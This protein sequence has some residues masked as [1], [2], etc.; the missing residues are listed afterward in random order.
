MIKIMT[1]TSA[2]FTVEEGNKMDVTVLPLCVSI[3]DLHL[4]DLCFDTNDFLERVKKGSVPSS[5]QPPIGDVIEAFE[6]C[7]GDEILSICMADGLSGTYETAM[8]AKDQMKHKERIHIM[9]SKTLCGPHRFLVEKAVRLRDEMRSMKEIIAGLE[10]S[11]GSM[12]SF[13]IPQDFSFLKR[14]GRLKPAAASIGGLLKLKPVMQQV[15][16]GRR[17]DTYTIKRTM[18]KAVS[19]VIASFQKLGVNENFKIYV[20]HAGAL[21]DAEKII[22][23]I[24]AVFTATDIEMLELSPAFITQGGPGC[25]AIQTILK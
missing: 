4:R 7:A 9:N 10:V 17:L 25:I 21:T 13:L 14:G 18:S 6:A 19:E 12:Q 15:D 11:M 3:D 22:A 2:L 5:S 20:S 23:Q 8:M 24:K 1:D 16:E